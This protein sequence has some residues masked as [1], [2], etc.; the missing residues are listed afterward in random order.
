MVQ[1]LDGLN[2]VGL[3]LLVQRSLIVEVMEKGWNVW[4]I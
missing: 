3:G 4:G 1:R 2:K